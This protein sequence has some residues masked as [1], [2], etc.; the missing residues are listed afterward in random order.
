MTPIGG[1]LDP[2]LA[3]EYMPAAKFGKCLFRSS[4]SRPGQTTEFLLRSSTVGSPNNPNH[5]TKDLSSS[6][7]YKLVALTLATSSRLTVT[8][9]SNHANLGFSDAPSSGFRYKVFHR[10]LR[11]TN[12]VCHAPKRKANK[13]IVFLRSCISE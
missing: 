13:S 6:S 10:L 4:A 12:F 5:N 8:D 7:Y 3:E 1:E 9:G 2:D 11:R